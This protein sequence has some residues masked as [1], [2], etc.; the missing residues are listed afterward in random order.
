M[1]EGGGSVEVDAW[2]LF[3]AALLVGAADPS[4]SPPLLQAASKTA[5]VQASHALRIFPAR[6]LP[7]SMPAGRVSGLLSPRAS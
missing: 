1:V 4:L 2:V 6:S 3:R 5:I 7:G